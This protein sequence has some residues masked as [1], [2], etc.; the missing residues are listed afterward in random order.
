[1]HTPIYTHI[2]W[3]I[4]RTLKTDQ[5]F[6]T[7]RSLHLSSTLSTLSFRILQSECM[8][9]GVVCVHCAHIASVYECTC[10]AQMGVYLQAYSTIVC[11]PIVYV[12]MHTAACAQRVIQ[13]PAPGAFHVHYHL[14][15]SGIFKSGGLGT[16]V[17]I[18]REQRRALRVSGGCGMQSAELFSKCCTPHFME[19]QG[20]WP[21]QP[22]RQT[23][24]N[25]THSCINGSLCAIPA[26]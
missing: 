21:G 14:F 11:A 16:A 2:S 7:P 23:K 8:G 9:V 3:W 13:L 15:Y 10:V 25:S 19:S 22:C 17:A 24:L 6:S 1:M 5:S 18:L 12:C 20:G 26:H 4:Y